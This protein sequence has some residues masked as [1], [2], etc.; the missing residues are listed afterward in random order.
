M[1][2]KTIYVKDEDLQIFEEAEKLGGDSLSSVIAEALRR[3][4][5]VK[6]AEQQGMKE[7]NLTVGILH[8]QGDDDIRTI[9]FVGRLLAEATVYSGQ[10]SDRRDR[11]TCYRVYQT[12]AGKILVW[13]KRWTRWEGG[14]DLLD[15]AV[16]DA[17][18]GY[19][20]EVYGKIHGEHLP[21]ETLPGSLLQEAAEALGEELVEF[22][23]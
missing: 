12:R 5:A 1:P 19:D 22:I 23:E 9:R 15:Y 10:T 21:P 13:W 7:C 11:G 4:V 18:P 20:E 6:R 8:A 3:F 14:S 17:L 2:N 16:F